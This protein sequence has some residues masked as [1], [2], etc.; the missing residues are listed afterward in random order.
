MQWGAG[1]PATV[2]DQNALPLALSIEA[3]VDGGR[4]WHGITGCDEAVDVAHSH[5]ASPG[6]SQHRYPVTLLALQRQRLDL[7]YV[8]G[9]GWC[10]KMESVMRRLCHGID[11]V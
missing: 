11:G 6:S 9:S 4:E 7:T 2:S 1:D 8:E 3:S 10:R 5:K